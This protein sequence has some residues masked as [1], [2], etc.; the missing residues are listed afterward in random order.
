MP[1]SGLGV[2]AKK[3]DLRHKVQIDSEE[4]SS[5]QYSILSASAK[6]LKRGGRMIYSTCTLAP[7]EN[8]GVVDKFLSENRDFHT[9][10]FNIG[11]YYSTNGSFTFIPHIHGTDGFF[12]TLFEKD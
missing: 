10:D 7:E 12:V 11:E 5:L 3:P 9:V 2:L 4:L 8:R 1:C 6:Y